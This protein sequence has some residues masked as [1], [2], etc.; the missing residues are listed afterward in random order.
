MRD[1]R[2]DDNTPV[3]LSPVQLVCLRWSAGGKTMKEVAMI[4][5]IS[6]SDVSFHL[7]NAR[8]ALG[9][10]SIAQAITTATRLQLI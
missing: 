5:G 8:G 2:E 4:E 3:R 9:A 6:V 10:V 7:S 1:Q